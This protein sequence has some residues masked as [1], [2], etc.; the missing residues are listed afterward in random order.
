MAK[1]IERLSDTQIRALTKEGL[2]PDGGNLYLKVSEHGKSWIFRFKRRGR[3]RDMG[4]GAYP[5]I[6]LSAARKLAE[7]RRV[8]LQAGVDP[9]EAR[10]QRLAAD[11]PKKAKMISF[12]DAAGQYIADNE[13]DWRN[14]KHRYQWRQSL[15]SYALPVIGKLNVAE[16]EVDDIERALRPI[17]RTKAETASR[18][19]G[20]IERI[21]DW[22][23]VRKF[24]DGENPARW[25]ANLDVLL[26]DQKAEVQHFASVPWA[27]IPAFMAE[28]RRRDN[29]S[30]RAL[31]FAILTAARTIEVIGALWTELDLGDAVWNVPAAR[32]K[33][34]RP[35]S[36]PLCERALVILEEMPRLAGNAFI[37]PGARP[38]RG[39]SNM[40]MLQL[41]RELR[42]GLTVHGFRS[43]FRTWAAEATNFPREVAEQQLA[44]AYMEKTES[45]Y[46]RGDLL[47]KRRELVEA[48]CAFCTGKV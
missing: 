37:F 28:L 41:L 23:K 18:L 45:A 16:I 32:M 20:R 3:T 10:R 34:K 31:E 44:H 13:Q 42:P 21:L 22:A 39:L 15:D 40:A 36:S 25:K 47:Q 5:A 4:L 9:I 29:I 24:R 43:S 35:H 17:W 19:R 46:Q 27:E 1:T 26:K 11:Q 33:A 6:R 8:E 12:A 38:K 7:E 14:A 48:W 30:A 2:Y